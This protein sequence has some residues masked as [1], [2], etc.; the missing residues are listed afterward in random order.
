MIET[1]TQ[2]QSK[3]ITITSHDKVIPHVFGV[4]ESWL[5]KTIEVANETVED[6]VAGYTMDDSKIIEELAVSEGVYIR[7]EEGKSFIF[8]W[9]PNCEEEVEV[10]AGFEIQLC[11]KCSEKHILPCNQCSE[12][13]CANC[14]LTKDLVILELTRELES[15]MERSQNPLELMKMKFETTKLSNVVSLLDE[16]KRV[17]NKRL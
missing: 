8:E 15:M 12:V 7:M 2:A 16:A 9:C 1:I 14:P 13:N 6:F 5:A 3:I 17:V 10:P 11:S 4:P